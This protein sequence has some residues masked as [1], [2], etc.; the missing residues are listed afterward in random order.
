MTE[1][2]A[3]VVLS[4]GSVSSAWLGHATNT[5]P[6]SAL[7]APLQTATSSLFGR[8]MATLRWK[9]FLQDYEQSYWKIASQKVANRTERFNYHFILNIIFNYIFY[10]N[11]DRL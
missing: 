11:E 9:T 1:S 2:T 8:A 4:T 10:Y 7:R 5:V 6:F 3:A